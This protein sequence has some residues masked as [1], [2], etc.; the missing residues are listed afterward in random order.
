MTIAPESQDKWERVYVSI[1]DITELKQI[2]ADLRAAKQDADQ[3]AQAKAE[4][5]ANM[6]HEIRTPLNAVIGM[7]SLLMDT[8]LDP[9][10]REYMEIAHSS[11]DVCCLRSTKSWIFPKL[12]REKLSWKCS[13]STYGNWLNLR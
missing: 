3:A 6:S 12:K 10:Q 9:E 7:S 11:S 2:Q 8:N 4:F 1:S 13:H 5:L